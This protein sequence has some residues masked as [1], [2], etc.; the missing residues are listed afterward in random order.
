MKAPK[1]KIPKVRQRLELKRARKLSTEIIA[2]MREENRRLEAEMTALR[3]QLDKLDQKQFIEDLERKTI[4]ALYQTCRELARCIPR[5]SKKG[6][7]AILR[8]RATFSVQALTPP[9]EF[10]WY[11]PAKKSVQSEAP[12]TP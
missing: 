8:A 10:R 5:N 1:V 2:S 4:K 3:E 9:V 12:S 6:R 7:E 11:R